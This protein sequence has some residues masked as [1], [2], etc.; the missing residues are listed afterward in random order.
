[1]TAVE[2]TIPDRLA[3]LF[4]G[5]GFWGDFG[6]LLRAGV[7]GRQVYSKTRVRLSLIAFGLCSHASPDGGRSTRLGSVSEIDFRGFPV[8]AGGLV[9]EFGC[10]GWGFVII[11]RNPGTD[12][13]PGRFDGLEGFYIKGWF[14]WWRQA[15]EPF[16]QTEE[17][18][19]EFDI[20]KADDSFHAFHNALAAGTF[21]GIGSPDAEDEV[22]P[23]RPHGAG[24]GFWRGGDERDFRLGFL[25]GFLRGRLD[26][27]CSGTGNAAGFVGVE[28]VVTNRLL[29]F[30]RD[31]LDGGGEK[32]G[33]FEDFEVAFGVP[34]AAG[35]VDDGFG[36]GDPRDFLEGERGAQ[37][38]LRQAAA[39]VGVV[40]GDGFF[41][42]GVDVEAAVFP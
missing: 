41:S 6:G 14:W 17:T 9:P 20:T 11:R 3:I 23:E 12:G 1:M 22:P 28:A 42:A 38:I 26:E 5:S 8:C 30:G 15:D 4:F 18:K 2:H 7:C 13:L 16:P 34:T 21:E 19:E 27:G 33:G 39:P 25:W 29:A 24:G 35:T 37:Q 36:I 32:V 10:V 31:V 40:G